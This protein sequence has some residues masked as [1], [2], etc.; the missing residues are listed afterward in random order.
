ML[1]KNTPLGKGIRSGYQTLLAIATFFVALATIPQV[2]D[3]VAGNVSYTAIIIPV[4]V[5]IFSYLQ[6]K[7]GK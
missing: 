1:D 4:L 2:Q 5:F 7:A 3:F 6:N